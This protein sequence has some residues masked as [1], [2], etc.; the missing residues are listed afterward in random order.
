MATIV[1]VHGGF[2]GGWSFVHLARALRARGHEVYTPTLTGLGERSHLASHA[3]N[4]DTHIADIANVLLWEDL[5]EVILLGHSYGGM[6]ITGVAERMPE[7][8]ASL[9]YMDAVVPKDGENLLTIRSEFRD[10]FL[11]LGAEH[12]GQFIAPFPAATHEAKAEAHRWLDAKTVPHPFA[13]FLQSITVSEVQA[14][15]R[16]VFIY[17]DGG[18]FGPRYEAFRGSTNAE[19]HMVTD[20]GHSLQIDQPERVANI[21]SS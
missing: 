13:C 18:W 8:I 5:S 3:I 21:L 4:L 1:L 14:N 6:V 19:V 12:K 11:S 10:L 2:Q 16:R 17:A 9:V 7:R 15:L 20:S